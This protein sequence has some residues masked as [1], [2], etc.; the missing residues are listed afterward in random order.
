MKEFLRKI[1][2]GLDMRWNRIEH[3]RTTMDREWKTEAEEQVTNVGYVTEETT[4]NTETAETYGK[5]VPHKSPFWWMRD[6]VTFGKS[7]KAIV[8]QLVHPK[9]LPVYINPKIT[10]ISV[11][12]GMIDSD[13]MWKVQSNPYQHKRLSD[14]IILDADFPTECMG[15]FVLVKDMMYSGKIYIRT[16]S[17]QYT[18]RFDAANS[19]VNF[20]YLESALDTETEMQTFPVVQMLGEDCFVCEFDNVPLANINNIE[21]FMKFSALDRNLNTDVKQDTHNVDYL[22]ED[23][24]RQTYTIQQDISKHVLRNATLIGPFIVKERKNNEPS[25][26]N[27]RYESI[28]E[29]PGFISTDAMQIV[30]STNGNS[31][32]NGYD[33]L[34]PVEVWQDY[35]FNFEL[36]TNDRTSKFGPFGE[37]FTPQKNMLRTVGSVAKNGIEIP[38]G[39]KYP[40]DTPA[41]VTIAGKEFVILTLEYGYV[42][43]PE[44]PESYRMR[45][46]VERKLKF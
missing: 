14:G 37:M 28:T 43:Q 26:F 40:Y 16:N 19:Y 23:Q 18:R 44:Y 1:F 45:V 2:H 6:F 35:Y 25:K 17:K 30:N 4:Y 36:Y 34:V 27:D 21:V 20:T 11:E 31:T 39:E 42:F 5:E 29:M 8:D 10:C 33:L 7:W 24:F 38:D 9:I 41:T 13:S 3:V 22:P 15:N 32:Y 46:V 12:A